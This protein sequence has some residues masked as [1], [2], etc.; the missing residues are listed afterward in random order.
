MRRTFRSLRGSLLLAALISAAGILSPARAQSA[1]VIEELAVDGNR[2]L[3]HEAFF[4]LTSLKVGDPYD[5]DVIRD[6]F[7][8]LWDRGLF[9][10][11][12]VES[13]DGATGKI[14]IF[15]VKERPRVN[16]IEYEKNKAVSETQ[17]EEQM[18]QRNIFLRIGAPVDYGA[19]Q[20]ALEVIRGVLG[21]KGFLDPFV[22]YELDDVDQGN[23]ALFF[24]IKPGGK[25]KV[26]TIEFVDNEIFSDSKLRQRMTLTKKYGWWKL[27]GRKKS[28][29]HPQKLDEDLRAV[30][31]YYRNS[32]YLDVRL[33]A[34]QVE[35]RREEPKKKAASPADDRGASPAPDPEPDPEPEAAASPASP[36]APAG[37]TEKQRRKREKKED[38]QRTKREEQQRRQEEKKRQKEDKKKQKEV[39]KIKTWVDI[40]VP[41]LEG[42]RYTVGE[43]R[44]EGNTVF[45]DEELLA[46][47]PLHPGDVLNEGLL[48]A[49]TQI[50][51][52]NYGERGYFFVS[53]NRLLDPKEGNVADVTIKID[54][55]KKY[56]IDRIEFSGNTTTRDYVL[57][58]ELGV[59]EEELFNLK[60]FRL[61]LRKVAQLGYFQLTREPEVIPVPGENRV[62]I[63]IAGVE[64]SRNE[65]Q[66]GGGF[67]GLDGGFFA[68]SFATRNFMGRG[69]TL[70]TQIQV[71]AANNTY[72]LSFQ[73]PWFMGRPWILG[74]SVFRRDTN[75]VGFE[76]VGQGASITLGKRVSNFTTLSFAYLIE[77][78][79]FRDA[80]NEQ[81]TRTSSVRPVL[82]WDTRNNFFRPSAGFRV[83]ASLEFA[84]G[85]L[86]GDNFFFKPNLQ[87]TVYVPFR[88]NTFF[89]LHGEIGYVDD[90]DGRVVPIFERF[91]LG[92]E[93]SLRIFPTRSVSPIDDGIPPIARDRGG[94]RIREPIN[95]LDPLGHI[96]DANDPLVFIGGNKY[97]LFNLEYVIPGP[98]DSP[99]EVAFFLDAGNA[100]KNDQGYDLTD[101]R[102]DAGIEV[103]FY[104]PIFG[105]PIRL[106]YG[107]NLDPQEFESKNDFIFSIGTTF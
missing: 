33:D 6:E 22:D 72:S 74:A 17:I 38:Q 2:S 83:V 12:S 3:S 11:L 104:L 82:V 9:E 21:S 23:K 8:R 87:T 61:G 45:S 18:T 49:G 30:E 19:I 70:S 60:E 73:E 95:P 63:N 4:R 15:H 47:F 67:S 106:I 13:R 29:Y 71:G 14:V 27:W 102:M 28:L 7:H 36:A 103:R 91:F 90:F 59:Q 99:V 42:P 69:Q 79:S 64:Q 75:F 94:R 44:I 43:I 81:T 97:L 10:D 1:A 66:V 93:R 58:R 92:G 39:G 56:F 34:P 100:W 32:G 84:G 77:E 25:T 86:G 20:D 101:M 55:D 41:V 31:D 78:I 57:R 50:I 88:G 51:E 40:K 35:I 5:E 80:F 89:G 16:S 98:R 52:I 53:T 54:E 96:V 76:Q 62:R 48:R 107:W 37:E 26:R 105:A 46:R 85:P 24:K 68:G 65:I